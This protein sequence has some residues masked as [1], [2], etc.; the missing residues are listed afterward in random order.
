MA[1]TTGFSGM[2][3]NPAFQMGMGLLSGNQGITGDAAFRNALRGGMGMMQASQ[4]NAANIQ[5]LEQERLLREMQMEQLRRQTE[6]QRRLTAAAPGLTKGLLSGDPELKRQALEGYLGMAGPQAI[7]SYLSAQL[8]PRQGTSLMQNLQA[9]GLQPGTPEYEQAMLEQL[10]KPS[11]VNVNVGDKP[12]PPTGYA[13]KDAD[14]PAMG[15]IPIPG[16]PVE[17]EQRKEQYRMGATQDALDR[18]R[19]VLLEVG[20]TWVQGRDKARLS[21]AY[22][23]MMIEMKELFNLGVLQGPDMA[24]MERTLTDPTTINAQLLQQIGGIQAFLGQL[25]LV[26]QK[27][28]NAKARARWL[29]TGAP[30]ESMMGPGAPD[31]PSTA[32]PAPPAGFVE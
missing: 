20:P 4:L 5:R 32:A 17:K 28:N 15:V 16:G 31:A 2:L 10:A 12:K 27:L 9:A 8:A 23:D 21:T 6:Q 25:D 22:N 14:N 26:Q 11:G 13:W 7:G 30:M 18:Y 19:S 1:T 29:S 24:I 3:G